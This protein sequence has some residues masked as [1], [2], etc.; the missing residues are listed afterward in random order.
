MLPPGTNAFAAM[1][2]IAAAD[3]V[4]GLF[5]GVQAR[6]L[7]SALF[8]GVG[9][10]SF[11]LVKQ[12]LGVDSPTVNWYPPQPS[13]QEEP[14]TSPKRLSRPGRWPRTAAV[15]TEHPSRNRR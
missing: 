7:M 2:T 4:A 12:R 1:R 10:A 3:G 14:R 6:L 15:T 13:E 11:E 9:F 8:G 5:V